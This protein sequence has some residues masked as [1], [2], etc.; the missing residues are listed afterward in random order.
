MMPKYNDLIITQEDSAISSFPRRSFIKTAAAVVICI[1]TSIFHSTGSS[2]HPV[3]ADSDSIGKKLIRGTIDGKILESRD[4][5]ASWSVCVD[6][7]PACSVKEIHVTSGGLRADVEHK[8]LSF[9][10]QSKD[11]R[12]WVG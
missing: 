6:F 5:G 8:G 9:T 4:N 11:G 2:A 12:N 3:V 7:G 10:V 1:G